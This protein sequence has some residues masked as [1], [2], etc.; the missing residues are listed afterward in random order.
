MYILPHGAEILDLLHDTRNQE[1]T[2]EQADVIP[3]KLKETKITACYSFLEIWVI[4]SCVICVPGQ[5]T[6]GS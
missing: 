2:V 6:G 3:M 4:C 5:Q 1:P